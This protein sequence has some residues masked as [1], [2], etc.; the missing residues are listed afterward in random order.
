MN[1]DA[2]LGQYRV[3]T[4]SVSS[5]I[6]NGRIMAVGS[7][8]GALSALRRRAAREDMIFS[9]ELRTDL[10]VARTLDAMCAVASKQLDN[11][12]A[13]HLRIAA[14]AKLMELARYRPYEPDVADCKFIRAALPHA[15]RLSPHNQKEVEWYVTVT[16]GRLLRK[17]LWREAL[18]LTPPK[19]YAVAAARSLLK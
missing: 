3:H 13:A 8:L 5:S 16:A 9:S 18:A 12:E 6:V 7:Q 15:S 19:N 1:I 4:A 11:L 10:K 17:G 2:K 14:A